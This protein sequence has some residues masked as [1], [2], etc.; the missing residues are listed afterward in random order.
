M[1]YLHQKL[2][3]LVR[4]FKNTWSKILNNGVHE[5]LDFDL[6]V[7]IRI[8]NAIAVV[9]S[10]FAFG[11]CMF[12]VLQGEY[13]LGL[14]DVLFIANLML[15]Y[16]L[17]YFRWY[18]AGPI[19]IFITVP[20][21]LLW[22]NHVYG[23][24]GTE[25]FFYAM[26]V[27]SFYFFKRPLNQF[28]ISFYLVALI[29]LTKYLEMVVELSPYTARVEPYILASNIFMSLAI[30]FLGISLFVSEHKKYKV[31]IESKNNQL[32]NALALANKK[33]EEVNLIL[34]ELNHRV[35][36]NLQMIS[37]L[38][39]IQ[40]YKTKS[41]ELKWAMK[42]A[43]NR[44]VSIAI[45]HQ[46]LYKDN[47]FYEVKL[48]RYVDELVNYLVQSV[49]S[50][51]SVKVSV[52]VEDVTLRIED[53]V[54]VGLIINELLTNALK[55]GVSDHNNQNA[56]SIEI[57]KK[58]V[59]LIIVVSDTGKGFPPDFD[60][61]NTDSFGFYL[62]HNIV[63][64]HEGQLILSSQGGARVEARLNIPDFGD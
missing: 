63:S 19:F 9:G 52:D 62:L 3:G 35:K 26:I 43:R 11:Y 44:I 24:I 29:L 1:I 61:M 54:H 14:R 55:Y 31:E 10:L 27:L 59:N 16:I 37:S 20:A 17:N 64:Q 30:L 7:R 40:S 39:N 2:L 34:R 38:F 49:S 36:N 60:I 57:S 48:K 23:T 53:T 42:D 58:N 4:I 13:L 5:G 46:K 8:S 50:T 15:M 33:N 12:L 6:V 47:L 32:N 18:K 45:M 56:V 21:I 51:D 41:S 28:L 25:Y 22:V